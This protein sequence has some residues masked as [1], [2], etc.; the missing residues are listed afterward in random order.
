MSTENQKIEL[1]KEMADAWASKDWRKAADM[2]AEDGVLHSMMVE[3]IV[4]REAVYERISGLGA[5]IEKILL[6]VDHMGVI[7]G[8]LYVE[9]W[10]R[11]TYNGKEGNLPVVG[12]LSFNDQNLITEWR[13]YYDRSSLLKEMGADEFDHAGRH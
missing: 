8:R 11:F 9:R 3:P 7:D 5:G 13:E 10:D 4:G 1:F 2:F 12:V 6:D